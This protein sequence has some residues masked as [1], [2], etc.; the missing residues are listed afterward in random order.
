MNALP[1]SIF[2]RAD[3]NL[4]SVSFKD[5]NGKYLPPVSTGKKT[6]EEAKQAAFL[7]LRDGI[8]QNNTTLRVNNLSLKDTV[9]KLKSSDEVETMLDELKRLGW[10]KGFTVRKT[11]AAVD[12]IS[13]LKNFWN[14]D[15][16]PYIEEKLRKKHGI[17]KRHCKQQGQ[18]I[19]LYW[20]E[21]FANRYLGEIVAKDIDNFIKHMGTKK[22]SPERKNLIIKAGTKP[23]RWAFSKGMVEIDPTRGHILYSGDEQKRKILTPTSASAIF[24]LNWK[25]ER[26]MLGNMLAAVTGMRCGEIQALRLQDIGCDC[27]YVQGSWN[28]EDG[29]KTTKNNDARTVELPFPYLL[30]R[31]FELAHKNPWGVSPTSYVFYSERK[32]DIPMHGTV[33]LD[34]MRKALMQTGFSKDQ[35]NSFV[36]HGWRHYFTSYMVKKLNKKLVKSETGIKTDKIL[37][38]YGDHETEGERELIQATKIETF[39]G[40]LPDFTE[41]KQAEAA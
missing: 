36:F 16:S 20:E 1:F 37:Y 18:A 11:E 25:N 19:V 39:A 2:K 13:F 40:L 9:R 12:F 3:R 4:Y 32:K 24:R 5:A 28:K 29:D 41:T 33:F 38:H 30:K 27:L 26:A 35:A 21:F 17:H 23:L 14:W 7:M 22:L 34:N 15:T 31:L 6:E 8:P 10:V